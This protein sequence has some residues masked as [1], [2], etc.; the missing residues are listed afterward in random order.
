MSHNHPAKPCVARIEAA[1][2]RQQIL[3]V[4]L[5]AI[6]TIGGNTAL[7]LAGEIG[8]DLSRFPS[9][10]HFCSWLGLAHLLEY[11]AV[12]GWQVAGQK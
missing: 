11:L 5:T 1:L 3:G 8:A 9:S 10:Q 7:V 12:I 6:P 2:N 4:D